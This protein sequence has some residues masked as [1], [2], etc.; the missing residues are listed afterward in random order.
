MK[1][2]VIFFIMTEV[3]LFM[4]MIRNAIVYRNRNRALEYTSKMVEKSIRDG[5]HNWRKHYD[6]L[7]NYD[8]YEKML[9][10]LTKWTYKDFYPDLEEIT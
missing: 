10:S 7:H 2:I 9:F 4:M 6:K 8:S 5:N 3:F 1:E